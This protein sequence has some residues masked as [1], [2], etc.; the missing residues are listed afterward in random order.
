M[1]DPVLALKWFC[2]FFVIGVILKILCESAT[3]YRILYGKIKLVP[4]DTE[5]WLAIAFVLDCVAA[6]VCLLWSIIAWIIK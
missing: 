5:G 6:I 3:K 2:L 4:S 1:G